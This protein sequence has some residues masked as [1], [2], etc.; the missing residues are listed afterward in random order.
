MKNKP[1]PPNRY[2]SKFVDEP[3]Q[4]M[5]IRLDVAVIE[6]LRH[7]REN[8]HPSVSEQIEAAFNMLPE[9]RDWM[10]L[11]SI[12]TQ[13]AGESESTYAQPTE[14]PQNEN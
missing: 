8:G 13:P 4:Q 5:C 9:F 10:A 1:Y 12:Q 6:F 3:R 14:V 11:A 7:R 2:R